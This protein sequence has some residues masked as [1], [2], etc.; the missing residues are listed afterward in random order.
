MLK[1]I[2]QLDI[3]YAEICK[4]NLGCVLQKNLR[5]RNKYFQSIEII[6]KEQKKIRD[7]YICSQF[8]SYLIEN[9]SIK[10]KLSPCLS[11]D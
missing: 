8:P 6:H 10:Y 7:V 9:D 3:R 2:Y 4:I 5:H 11:Y 1:T